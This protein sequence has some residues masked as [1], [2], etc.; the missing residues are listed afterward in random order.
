MRSTPGK[1]NYIALL[2]IELFSLLAALQVSSACCLQNSLVIAAA[3]YLTMG[4]R[5]LF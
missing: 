5:W 3:K 1:P 4:R 2:F